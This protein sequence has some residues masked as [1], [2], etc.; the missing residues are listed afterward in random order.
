LQVEDVSLDAAAVEAMTLDPKA[1]QNA[2][3]ALNEYLRSEAEQQRAYMHSFP[4]GRVSLELEWLDVHSMTQTIV[5]AY[6]AFL[7]PQ[8]GVD[9]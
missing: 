2:E 9:L 4:D 7:D 5:A 1:I 8:G 3:R 6:M